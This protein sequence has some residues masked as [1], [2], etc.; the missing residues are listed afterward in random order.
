[1]GYVA[2]FLFFAAAIG[3]YQAFDLNLVELVFLMGATVPG[4]SYI[5][6]RLARPA[7]RERMDQDQPFTWRFIGFVTVIAFLVFASKN[8]VF[9]HVEHDIPRYAAIWWCAFPYCCGIFLIADRVF[10]AF[11]VKKIAPKSAPPPVA[12]RWPFDSERDENVIEFDPK[13]F[14]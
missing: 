10:D 14:K 11:A 3:L 13:R 8:P 9:R 5:T 4:A 6:D 1:L 7:T 12:P 2:L